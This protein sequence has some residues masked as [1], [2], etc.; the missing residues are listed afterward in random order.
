MKSSKIIISGLVH[1]V[2]FRYFT[3]LNANKQNVFGWVRN[4]SNGTVEIIVS[5]EEKNVE[6]FIHNVIQ[7]SKFSRID[8]ID[9]KT[10][11]YKKF[12]SFEIITNN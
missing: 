8:S 3:K 5:G 7:G 12:E 6:N 11:K 10:M 4:N 2:G 9:I 1:G